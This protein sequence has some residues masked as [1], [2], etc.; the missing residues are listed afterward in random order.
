[1]TNPVS[2]RARAVHQRAMVWDAHCDTLQRVIMDDV[3]LALP[4]DAHC[5]LPAWQAGGVKAQV[6]A[7][8]VDTIYAPD[9]AARR[10]LEQIAAFHKFL[11]AVAFGVLADEEPFDLTATAMTGHQCRRCHRYRPDFETTDGIHFQIKRR[12]VE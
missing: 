12:F 3:D 10:A 7:V 2:A 8:W 6:F 1:M 5:D 11:A 4:S 9:H